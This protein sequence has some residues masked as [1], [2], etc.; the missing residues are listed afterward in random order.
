MNR[1]DRR[2][3]TL[4]ELLTTIA[5]IGLLASIAIPRYQQIKKKATAAEVVSAMTTARGAAYNYSETAGS[6][7]ATSGLGAVPTGMGQYLPGGGTALFSG[8]N[9]QLGWLSVPGG[10]GFASSQILY[11]FM[12]DG[13]ICQSVYGMWGGAANPDILGVCGAGGGF[14]FLYIDR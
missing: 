4:V 3:F 12:T 2:G 6:W 11:A 9:H 5:V 7:P 13:V 8:S 10:F 1:L 14:V